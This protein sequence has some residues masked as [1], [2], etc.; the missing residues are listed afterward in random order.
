MRAD[1]ERTAAWPAAIAAAL[2]LAPQVAAKATRDALFLSSYAVSALPRMAAVAALAS[3]LATFAF[4]RAM[5][6]RSPARVMPL[7]LGASALLFLAEWPLALAAPRFAAIVVYLHHAVLGAVLVSGFWSLVNEG[8]DPHRARHAMGAIG[9]GASLGGAAG[10]LAT[11]QAARILS[12]P[13][14]L[15]VLALTSAVGVISILRL[16]TAGRPPAHAERAADASAPR[17]ALP[18][19]RAVPYLR[20][21]ALLVLLTAALE[22]VLDYVLSAAAAARFGRGAPLMSFF[23]LFHGG[24][25][26]LA[27]GVQATLVRPLL[28]GVGLARTLALQPVFAAVASVAA[29]AAPRFTTLVVLRGGQ[30]VF[31][32]SAFRSA[33]ELLYTPLPREQKRPAKVVI[34]VAC[35]RL[36]TVLGSGAVILVLLIAPLAGTRLLLGLA[37]AV[38]AATI[39]LAPRF[40]G[41]YVDALAA[42]LRSGAG[43]LDAPSVVEPTTLLTLASVQIPETPGGPGSVASHDPLLQAI[44]DLRSGS[45]DRIQPVLA[46]ELLDPL[47]AG[48]VIPLLARTAFFPAALA[49]LRR[50][51]PYCTGLLVDALLDER[52]EPVVR[53][54]VARVLRAVPTQRAADGLLA[55][56][57]AAR[58]DVRYRCAQALVRLRARNDRLLFPREKVLA[59]AAREADQVAG[60]DR[61]L[62]HVFDLLALVLD[63]EPVAMALAALRSNDEALRGTAL[64]YLENVLPAVVKERLWPH[65]SRGRA[66]YASGRSPDEI[67]ADLL[68]STALLTPPRP[69]GPPQRAE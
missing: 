38:A 53:R 58:F 68:R 20:R 44:A 33:Y 43:A 63:R 17:D 37:A 10:G 14:M 15:P 48:H 18:L 42:S 30:A 36:G 50:A 49:C 13:A 27:L 24:S 3:L 29:V 60:S 35:D 28:Q 51:A 9:A 69:P 25:G 16:R 22:A 4:S 26:L 56:L 67:Q 2:L 65:L 31:R 11:W 32:N 57:E 55:G 52:A 61:H 39:A 66:T 54:R 7:A 64:E 5:A 40:H 8:F 12:V 1:A 6:S 46:R 34:D 19:I 62:E 59:S 47:L 41:G 45:P 21:L 23:A